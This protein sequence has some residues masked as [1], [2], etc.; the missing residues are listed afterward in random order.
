MIHKTVCINGHPYSEEN[1]Y[2]TKQGAQR[3]RA[4]N[5]D[6]QNRRRANN[7]SDDLA[8]KRATSVPVTIMPRPVNDDAAWEVLALCAQTDPEAFFPEKGE[9]GQNGKDICA[10]C[11]VT[12]ACLQYALDNDERFGIYGGLSP[13]ERKTLKRQSA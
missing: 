7:Q 5:R 9:K 1:T 2:I 4:C 10:R 8:A 6:E 13:Q 11:E 12:A 3:C